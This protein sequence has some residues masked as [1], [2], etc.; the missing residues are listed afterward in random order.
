MLIEKMS[1]EIKSLWK[2]LKWYLNE[3]SASSAKGLKEV[4]QN[5]ILRSEN[6][7]ITIRNKHNGRHIIL[8]LKRKEIRWLSY[9]MAKKQEWK[10]RQTVLPKYLFPKEI[11]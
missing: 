11:H 10:E 3:F 9:R 4:G 5:I 7:E 1:K 2:Y 8:E 6:E